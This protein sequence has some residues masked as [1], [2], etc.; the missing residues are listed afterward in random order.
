MRCEEFL[1]MLEAYIEDTLEGP[2]REAFR[3]HL[4]SCARCRE[5][6]VR[7]DPTLL[8][9]A[10]R[11]VEPDPA[12]IEGCTQAV[13][14]EIRQ[15]RLKRRLGRRRRALLAAAAALLVAIVGGAAWKIAFQGAEPAPAEVAEVRE[16]GTTTPPPRVEVD[17]VGD[18]VRVYQFAEEDGGDSAVYFIVNP[19]L[20][21]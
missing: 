5:Q 3:N 6:A 2:R 4:A 7:E 1:E 11:S 13:L 19:A 12:Q 14:S 21:L 8:F 17:M 9:S 15:D 18:G 16:V 20:E 10:A